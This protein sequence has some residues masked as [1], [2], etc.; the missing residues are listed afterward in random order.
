MKKLVCGLSM[1]LVLVLM[2]GTALAADS[3]TVFNCY[4]YIDENLLYEFTD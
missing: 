1:V 3:I 2:A 4:D